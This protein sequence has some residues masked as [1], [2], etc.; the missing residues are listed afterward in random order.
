[1][2]KNYVY[3][4]VVQSVYDGDTLRTDIDLGFSTWIHNEPLRLYGID[5]PEIRGE[6]RPE[7]LIARDWL[8]SQ[9]PPGTKI[10]IET[11]KDSREKYGRYLAII[12]LNDTNLNEMMVTLGF[13]KPF[14]A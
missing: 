1:M 14:M 11:L 5:A 4:A 12:Y 10:V 13:A 3:E 7:G 8:R 9:L 6:E 2:K